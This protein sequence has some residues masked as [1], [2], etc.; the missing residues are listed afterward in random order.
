M[1]CLFCVFL[2]VVCV[3]MCT[4]LLP[5]GG[6]SISVNKFIISQWKL[7]VDALRPFCYAF[8][9]KKMGF[10][11]VRLPERLKCLI[12]LQIILILF[13]F[14]MTQGR[15]ILKQELTKH[16]LD[17]EDYEHEICDTH[18]W[19]YR[20]I[21]KCNYI[22]VWSLLALWTVVRPSRRYGPFGQSVP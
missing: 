7:S 16:P 13:P 3:Q 22:S 15:V 18:I 8:L 2:C 19:A 20:C 1:Y 12:Y 11:T 4:V 5:P 10:H 6:Y 17:S 9:K 21:A 14:I